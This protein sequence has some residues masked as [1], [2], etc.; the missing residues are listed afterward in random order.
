MSKKRTEIQQ[1]NISIRVVVAVYTPSPVPRYAGN[2]LIEALPPLPDKK[3]W[4][5]RLEHLPALDP[6]QRSLP[7][8]L[9][10]HCALEMKAVFIV[11]TRHLEIC[12]KT[13]LLLRSAY[14][15][16]SLGESER[17]RR[18]QEWYACVQNGQ[19]PNFGNET[20]ASGEFYSI[21]G[22]SGMGKTQALQRYMEW[23]PDVI[24]HPDSQ[25]LQ[26]PIIY[27]QCPH[28]G[29]TKDF[30]RSIL[31]V[32]DRLL[33]TSYDT[34]NSR[35]TE[36]T[37]I[38][39]AAAL[40]EQYFVGLLV[41]DEIQ[42][43]SHKKSGGREEFVD[44]FLQLFNVLHL[45]II[46][47]G[48]MKAAGV[49][50]TTFRQARRASSMGAVVWERFKKN[51]KGWIRLV[52]SLWPYQWQSE[53]TPLTDEFLLVLYDET[54]GITALLVRLL[55]LVQHRAI[56]L[57]HDS[58][59]PGLIRR[60]AKDN[61]SLLKVMLAALRSG[62]PARIAKFDDFVIPDLDAFGELSGAF[63]RESF[64]TTESEQGVDAMKSDTRRSVLTM[65]LDLGMSEQV[66]EFHLN[67]VL[68]ANPEALPLDIMN[69]VLTRIK[70]KPARKKS[71]KSRSKTTD[72][73]K[74][75]L[76][77]G[78]DG[79]KDAGWLSPEGGLGSLDDSGKTN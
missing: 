55:I 53:P 50:Q 73:G 77:T 76:P 66:A 11:Q 5:A 25:R 40:M 71:T 43:L 56:A 13:D 2:P 72:G 62:N 44:F 63:P 47:I 69:D 59:K 15:G 79:A 70:G 23:M 35:A 38:A 46:V 14:V 41:I 52:N 12:E 39:I 75:E 22:S 67:A 3:Q 24:R 7:A 9:R 60:V 68:D 42:N 45:S 61:F 29:S 28:S 57:G 33:G 1:L 36:E 30:A 18:A 74:P 21:I 19:V 27:V 26:I 10:L 16:V 4:K 8:E 6:L 31:R 54:Q 78:Y 51:D 20:R 17:R 34:E 49:L 48:T 37:L 32:F 65:L 58:L 64:S